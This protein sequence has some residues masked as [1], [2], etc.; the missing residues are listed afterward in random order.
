[1]KQPLCGL[2]NTFANVVVREP[3]DRKDRETKM[4]IQKIWLRKKC[5]TLI[6]PTKW[7]DISIDEENGNDEQTINETD[8]ERSASDNESEEEEESMTSM[9]IGPPIESKQELQRLDIGQKIMP[10]RTRQ[11]TSEAIQLV[12]E[13]LDDFYQAC[14]LMSAI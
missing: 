10:G 14:A 4:A 1:V 9:P 8:I 2:S 7:D 3:R 5:K 12:E 13:N 11:Q 6:V